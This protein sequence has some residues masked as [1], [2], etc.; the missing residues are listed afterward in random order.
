MMVNLKQSVFNTLSNDT[1][2]RLRALE[3]WDFSN[4]R[5]R[6]GKRMNW[7]PDF[8]NQVEE[9]YHKFMALIV[10]NPN[11]LY[12]MAGPVDEFWHEHLLD[13]QDYARFSFEIAGTF[14]HHSPTD[15][16]LFEG[17]ATS[18]DL[19]RLNTLPDLEEF[20]SSSAES[21]WGGLEMEDRCGGSCHDKRSKNDYGLT[22]YI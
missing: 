19:F 12:G 7:R 3:D 17:S 4:V 14:I 21:I 13:S 10:I 9:E 16:D 6:V 11:K 2:C 5:H 15:S 20:F 22:F 18:V 8:V 1:K